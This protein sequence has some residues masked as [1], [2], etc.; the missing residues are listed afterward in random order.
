[1]EL[2]EFPQ[3]RQLAKCCGGGGGV[4]AFANDL[5]QD[6]ALAR[7]KQ[8]IAVGADTVV[9]A[10]PSCKNSLNQGAARARKE[11]LGKVKVLDITEL[12]AGRLAK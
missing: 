10:C 6:I 1:M 8:A 11:K 7:I 5:N 3:N 9:S 12:V 2:I 4:K